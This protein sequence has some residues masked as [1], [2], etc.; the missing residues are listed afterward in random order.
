M[1]ERAGS[2]SPLQPI[3][4]VAREIELF[5]GKR[6]VIPF[7]SFHIIDRDESRLAALRQARVVR[8]KLAVDLMSERFDRLPLLR[9]VRFGYARIFPNARDAHGE[10]DRKWIARLQNG[11]DD[12]RGAER[13]RRTGERD[14]ALS[15]EQT[16][17]RIESD[18]ACARD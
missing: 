12:R 3:L 13:R 11:S 15:S 18:P 16:R 10:F 5:S 1:Q 6:G 14:V 9:G 2:E 7:R 8:C 17:S 4:Q